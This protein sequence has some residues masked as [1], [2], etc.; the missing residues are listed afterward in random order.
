[1]PVASRAAAQVTPTVPPDEPS[2]GARVADESIA[3]AARTRYAL[4]LLDTPHHGKEAAH[5]PQSILCRSRLRS[6][7]RSRRLGLT[8]PAACGPCAPRAA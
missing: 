8:D 6:V 4:H 2:G 5:A 1:M 3:S 7:G